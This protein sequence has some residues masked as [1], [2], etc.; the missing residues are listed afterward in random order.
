MDSIVGTLRSNLNFINQIQ[1]I[2]LNGA[3]TSNSSSN[4]TTFST[5][6]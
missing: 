1:F 5:S 6:S 2:S 3:T 4:S